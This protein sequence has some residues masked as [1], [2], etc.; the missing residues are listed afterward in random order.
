M[1]CE[2]GLVVTFADGDF[3]DWRFQEARGWG[4]STHFDDCHCIARRCYV[5]KRK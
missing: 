2:D 4:I 5:V 3:D 1:R